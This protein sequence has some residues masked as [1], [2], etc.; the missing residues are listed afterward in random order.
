PI[1]MPSGCQPFGS[2]IVSGNGR[3]PK[4]VFAAFGALGALGALGPLAKATGVARM[5]SAASATMS[6]MR[7]PSV[8]VFASDVTHF[9]PTHHC[10]SRPAI[11]DM[12]LEAEQPHELQREFARLGEEP[13]A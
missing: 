10:E 8:E 7:S 9:R 6:R 4:D 5:V 12:I 11:A 2:A 13:A 1:A 3:L